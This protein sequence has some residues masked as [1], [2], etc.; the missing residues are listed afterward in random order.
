V[1]A[2][3]TVLPRLKLARLPTPLEPAQRLG[4]AVGC[5][6][7]FLKREDHSGLGLGGNKPRQL[8]VILARA[9]AEG[10]D[11]I[12]TTAGAQSNFCREAAAACAILG[13][14]CALLLRG[15][16][17]APRDGNLLLCELFGADIHWHDTADPYSDAIQEHL[18]TLVQEAV[19]A[20]RKPWLVRLPGVTGPLS[21]AGAISLADELVEQWQEPAGH[22]C[23]AVGSGLTA[24]GLLAGFAHHGIDSTVL[25]MSVQQPERFIRPLILQRA[26]EALALLGSRAVI[27]PAR[28]I[29]DDSVIG[30]GYGKPSED[31]VAAARLAARD[32]GLV[33][34]PVYTAKALAGLIGHLADGRIG[35]AESVVFVHTGSVPGLMLHRKL[36]VEHAG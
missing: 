34:D 23:L 35:K 13:W 27:D 17:S 19:R 6:A 21:A 12:V 16:G 11:T 30:P 25:A 3:A 10:A 1:P 14:K 5:G 29:V 15:D 33:L 8:E 26:G 9:E 32:A 2:E 28:L 22:V 36:F 20:G 31:S 7:L 4:A 24:A 18:D